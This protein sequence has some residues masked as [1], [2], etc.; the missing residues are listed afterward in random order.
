MTQVIYHRMIE[1]IIS[2]NKM[3]LIFNPF[4]NEIQFTRMVSNICNDLS[5][6]VFMCMT[7][8]YENHIELIEDFLS[9]YVELLNEEVLKEEYEL[10]YIL[11]T[12][13]LEFEEKLKKDLEDR[14]DV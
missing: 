5:D 6:M 13:F 2:S 8:D 3:K 10:A 7:A 9:Y 11:H 4:K 14:I 1:K 12:A